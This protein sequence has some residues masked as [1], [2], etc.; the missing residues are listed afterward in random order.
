MGAATNGLY[1]STFGRRLY[2]LELAEKMEA[3]AQDL[4]DARQEYRRSLRLGRA[5]ER[6][7][8][9]MEASLD[10]HYELSIEYDRAMAR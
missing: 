8:L 4:V 1:S 10:N 7:R 5:T 2:V 3:A 9:R 6:Q